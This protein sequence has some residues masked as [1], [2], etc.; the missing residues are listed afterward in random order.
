MGLVGRLGDQFGP[1]RSASSAGSGDGSYGCHDVVLRSEQDAR[2]LAG[3]LSE[4]GFGW[5]AVTAGESASL[6]GGSGG[7][8]WRVRAIDGPHTGGDGYRRSYAAS[9]LVRREARLVRG[10][11]AGISQFSGSDVGSRKIPA[12]VVLERPGALPEVSLR[13]QP[14]PPADLSAGLDGTGPAGP[15]PLTGLDDVPW[16]NLDGAYGGGE[17]MRS[18]LQELAAPGP[19]GWDWDTVD[20]LDAGPVHQGTCYPATPP[21]ATFVARIVSTGGL[22]HRL[23]LYLLS[24]LLHAADQQNDSILIDWD[25]AL[26]DNRQ[27]RPGEWTAGTRTAIATELPA[28]LAG[29]EHEPDAVRYLLAALAAVCSRTDTAPHPA[30]PA[31]TAGGRLSAVAEGVD[32]LAVTVEATRHGDVLQIARALLTGHDERA[33]TVAAQVARWQD[34]PM[35]PLDIHQTPASIGAAHVLALAAQHDLPPMLPTA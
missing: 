15:D 8:G 9:M 6:G 30:A 21:T 16:A 28:L 14:P 12:P 23:R 11:P 10:V 35:D 34:P 22:P 3:R 33:V 20:D 32:E 7:P 18:L 31:N 4:L 5:V 19:D 25:Q 27:P 2:A 26:A 24:W 1:G 29:W 17:R 13:A